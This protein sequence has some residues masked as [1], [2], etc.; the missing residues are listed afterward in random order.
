MHTAPYFR[1]AVMGDK[2]VGKWNWRALR[3]RATYNSDCDSELRNIVAGLPPFVSHLISKWRHRHRLYVGICERGNLL[4]RI[5]RVGN[6]MSQSYEIIT[7]LNLGLCLRG[8]ALDGFCFTPGVVQVAWRD[9]GNLHAISTLNGYLGWQRRG[10]EFL[11]YWW[12]FSVGFWWG[13][14]VSA[15]YSDIK[16]VSWL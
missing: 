11:H 4:T 10:N 15:T 16:T 13:K 7:T 6:I 8:K 14:L 12:K 2:A 9:A 5:S 1:C 3:V